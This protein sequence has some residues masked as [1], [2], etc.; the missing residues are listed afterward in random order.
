MIRAMAAPIFF[1]PDVIAFTQMNTNSILAEGKFQENRRLSSSIKM[2]RKK[3]AIVVKIHLKN[4]RIHS[5]KSNFCCVVN[6]T[7]A[8]LRIVSCE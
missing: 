2:P 5:N 7:E 6:L 4:E 8:P 1:W 3:R